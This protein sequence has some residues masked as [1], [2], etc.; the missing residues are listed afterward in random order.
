MADQ[1]LSQFIAERGLLTMTHSPEVELDII[2]QRT[3]SHLDEP[4]SLAEELLELDAQ[5]DARAGRWEDQKWEKWTLSTATVE[6]IKKA[7]RSFKPMEETDEE[8]QHWGVRYEPLPL[9]KDEV[10]L[11]RKSRDSEQDCKLGEST[12]PKWRAVDELISSITQGY[13]GELPGPD[14]EM[15]KLERMPPID[16]AL[17][18][19]LSAT[20]HQ[21][22]FLKE[23]R[24]STKAMIARADSPLSL[25]A[26]DCDKTW[27]DL[28]WQEPFRPGSPPI[29][30]RQHK[31][32]SPP[33]QEDA[34]LALSSLAGPLDSELPSSPRG[35]GLSMEAWNQIEE[36]K[37]FPFSSPA[38]SDSG[39]HKSLPPIWSSQDDKIQLPLVDSFG[40]DE[41]LFPRVPK[42]EIPDDTFDVISEKIVHFPDAWSDPDRAIRDDEVDELDSDLDI[43]GMARDL[44]LLEPDLDR[45]NATIAALL[46]TSSPRPPQPDDILTFARLPIPH[47]ASPS[48]SPPSHL[49]N[50]SLSDLWHNSGT[51][52]ALKPATGLRS[53][54]IDLPWSIW[55]PP[56]ADAWAAWDEEEGLRDAESIRLAKETESALLLALV[57]DED[58]SWGLRMG[59][60][61]KN[62]EEPEERLIPRADQG[63]ARSDT[64][65]QALLDELKNETPDAEQP[66][67]TPGPA[68][69][70]D[71]PASMSEAVV[72]SVYAGFE[73]LTT[74]DRFETLG[75]TLSISSGVPGKLVDDSERGLIPRK[76]SFPSE[77]EDDDDAEVATFVNPDGMAYL[78]ELG[79]TENDDKDELEDDNGHDLDELEVDELEDLAES[80]WLRPLVATALSI[81][82]SSP[83]GASS[84]MDA[85]RQVAPAPSQNLEV[86]MGERETP[87][88]QCI[89]QPLSTS[90]ATGL[91]PAP[92]PGESTRLASLDTLRPSLPSLPPAPAPTAAVLRAKAAPLHL[93][94]KEDQHAQHAKPQKKWSGAPALSRFLE[95]RGRHAPVTVAE[96]TPLRHRVVP[97]AQPAT[98]VP[99][100]PTPSHVRPTSISVPQFLRNSESI[101][102]GMLVTYRVV[103]S[104]DLFQMI[105]HFR[106][107][108]EAQ[109]TLIDRPRRY[110]HQPHQT[111]EPHL[112]LDGKTCVIFK[113][114]IKIVGSVYRPEELLPDSPVPTSRD[115]AVVTTLSRL[116][117]QFDR[118]LLVLEEASVASAP[119]RPFAYTPPVVHA[120]RTLETTLRE[121]KLPHSCLAE[122]AISINPTE[123]A[124]IVRTFVRHLNESSMEKMDEESRRSW[125]GS[126]PSE[127]EVALLDIP[128]LNHISAAAIASLCPSVASFLCLTLE[129]RQHN[130]EPV[131]S[132]YR[133][134]QLSRTLPTQPAFVNLSS[135]AATSYT[136]RDP[137][138]FA[139]DPGQ[140]VEV[141]TKEADAASPGYSEVKE[142]GGQS[143]EACR[144]PDSFIFAQY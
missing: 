118:I 34:K 51:P 123:S 4:V 25:L 31:E 138:Y 143:R 23:F 72:Q 3:L 53:L 12:P 14:E 126:D 42:D 15:E 135:D 132:F 95:L 16:Q 79:G 52:W 69:R 20:T 22:Q 47:I 142:W 116:A 94:P 104:P 99:L 130:F 43:P 128:E 56:A 18:L 54:T 78:G 64:I 41:I 57:Q 81:G 21:I 38:G 9:F 85:T 27:L 144:T 58:E 29:F 112:T 96:S 108:S 26:E 55:E 89:S 71:A 133:M 48:P 140:D 6:L 115:E 131:C 65:D 90:D 30:A 44:A 62:E 32:V 119:T 40:T 80:A 137:T 75:T 93:E 17:N 106:A 86:T 129:D 139:S 87:L 127:I 83:R 39:R 49:L 63:G 109:L 2:I 125:L 13:S 60:A 59:K 5:E 124:T 19:G 66:E 35:K 50:V 121:K 111:L 82:C 76:R 117:G 100:A 105:E 67:P 134:E 11:T 114:L 8:R 68:P 103:A 74:F 24:S 33:T 98:P 10:I 122:F 136:F 110:P 73:K 36:I 120:L 141:K 113:P 91:I 88:S 77:E 7:R 107:L 84:A 97:T 102:D 70:P 45:R 92:A 1:E 101:S 61:T 46:Y 37:P 28:N